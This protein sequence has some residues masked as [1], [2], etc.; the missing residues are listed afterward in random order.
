MTKS[1]NG[2]PKRALSAWMLF[3]QDRRKDLLDKGMSIGDVSKELSK[4]WKV[5]SD[6]D[7]EKYDKSAEKAKEKYTKDMK[8]WKKTAPAEEEQEWGESPKKKKEK[9]K[10]NRKPTGYLLFGKDVRAELK[11]E[12]S[13][14]K[15]SEVMTEIGRRWREMSDDKK[16]GYNADAKKL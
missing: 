5:V 7:K 6:S 10:G 12:N 15:A 4:Q 8:E 11:K 14:L 13:D 9:K 1:S 16:G 3:C 2:K